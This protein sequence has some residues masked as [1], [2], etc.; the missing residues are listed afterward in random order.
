MNKNEDIYTSE[1]VS[2][3][4]PVTCEITNKIN[5]IASI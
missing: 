3:L 1:L 4:K 5:D 2:I